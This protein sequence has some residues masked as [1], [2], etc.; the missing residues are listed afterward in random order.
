MAGRSLSRRRPT[1]RASPF[2]CPKQ[3]PI[4]S[5]RACRVRSRTVY[6]AR[7]A[8]FTPPGASPARRMRRPPAGRL[9]P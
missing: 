2:G 7:L 9:P 4:R 6:R 8:S 1:R 5:G 3:L